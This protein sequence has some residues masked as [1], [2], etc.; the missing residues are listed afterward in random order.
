MVAQLRGAEFE[1][2]DEMVIPS[3]DRSRY[4][5]NKAIRDVAC[6]L[7]FAAWQAYID[8]CLGENEA[9]G[10]KLIQEAK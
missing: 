10:R 1:V 6:W 5:A 9:N 3:R 2:N 8:R 4:I 7:G